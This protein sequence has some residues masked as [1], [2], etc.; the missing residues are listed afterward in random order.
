M[1]RRARHEAASHGSSGADAP[2]APQ[3]GA[4][5]PDARTGDQGSLARPLWRPLAL[6]A[7]LAALF[8]GV[9]IWQVGPAL[10][11]EFLSD[12]YL[13]IVNNAYVHEL[14]WENVQALLD[15]VGQPVAY[16]LNYAPV[17]LL[18][19]ALEY[20]LF[21][22]EDMLGWH[23]VNAVAHGLTSLLLVAFLLRGGLGRPAALFGGAFFLV[24]PANVETVAWIFQL[25]TIVALALSLGALMALPRR[26][27]LAT[28]LFGVALLTKITAL[29]ALPVAVVQ[30]WV[31]TRDGEPLRWGWVVAW[32]GVALVVGLLEMRAFQIQEDPRLVIHEDPLVHARSIVA[33]AMRYLVMAATS[34]GVSTY[35]E[36]PPAVSWLDPWWLAGLA[37]LAVLGTRMVLTLWRR[38]EEAAFWMLAAAS[39]APVSQIFP[40]IYPMAD[41]YLYGI[42]PGLVGGVLLA[43]RGPWAR[44]RAALRER[45]QVP[46]VRAQQGVAVAACALLA[47]FLVR[48]HDRASVYESNWNAMIDAALNYPE[49]M[50]AYLLKGH[51]AAREGDAR[52]SA[53]AFSRAV[54]LGLSDLGSL[55]THPELAGVRSH[56]AFRAVLKDLAARDIARLEDRE[57]PG[58]SELMALGL[59]YQVMEQ[60][61]RAIRAYE[62]ALESG[63]PFEEHI[64]RELRAMR[65]AETQRQGSSDGGDG[66]PGRG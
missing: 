30:A 38:E 8:V 28:V 35:Q 50:Q 23:V 2:R 29:A 18:L 15:P 52:A 7:P 60:R 10:H 12:D 45:W 11:G 22:A 4:P 37:V 17:H 56:P 33:F 24:H 48:S 13:Y 65:W 39:F 3:R 51:R 47:V 42:L 16:T 58:Q 32:V 61:E 36:P 40:F 20:E 6:A 64:R 46:P 41:R 1:S 9:A 34:Y 63:G 5:G 31:R 55:V 43:L 59:A 53:R 26:P 44:A 19:H 66:A 54:E 14:S 49:G 21:G 25:K 57:S 27:T 62:A